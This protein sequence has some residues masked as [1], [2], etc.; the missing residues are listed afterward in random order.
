MP[1]L[2]Y[3]V[4]NEDKKNASKNKAGAIGR[5]PR[6]HR[7][8]YIFPARRPDNKTRTDKRV[9]E[10]ATQIHEWSYALMVQ[11][12][13]HAR[14]YAR[15]HASTHS[16]IK[17]D[18][19]MDGCTVCMVVCLSACSSVPFMVF[20]FTVLW[21]LQYCFKLLF[22]LSNELQEGPCSVRLWICVRAFVSV[23]ACVRA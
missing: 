9:M 6:R 18:G 7:T 8:V 13:H 10:G 3:R 12:A 21:D 5:C 17:G 16:K 22:F 1:L 14:T 11:R 19:C 23:R 4:A 15:T 20:L 2:S